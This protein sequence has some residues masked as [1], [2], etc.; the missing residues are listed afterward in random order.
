MTKQNCECEICESIKN[1][2]ETLYWIN[3]LKIITI[4]K[5]RPKT[6]T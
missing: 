1:Q 5:T 6:K 2:E 4:P 3:S